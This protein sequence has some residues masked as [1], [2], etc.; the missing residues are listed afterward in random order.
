VV[1]KDHKENRRRWAKKYRE[2]HRELIRDSRR[3]YNILHKH[4]KSKYSIDRRH[5][6][7]EWWTWVVSNLSCQDC[8]YEWGSRVGIMEFHHTNI[9]NKIPITVALL[10]GWE[11]L[12]REIEKGIFL[13]PTCHV[14][15]HLGKDGRRHTAN[16]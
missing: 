6:L 7:V 15:R 1:N 14:I 11:T 5:E 9:R 3:L 2:E 8:G 16:R 13:C 12:C 10:R 4:D